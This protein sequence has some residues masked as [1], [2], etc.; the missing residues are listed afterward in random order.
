LNIPTVIES[1]DVKEYQAQSHTSLEE[2]AREVRY[3]FLTETA[4][5]TGAQAVAVGHTA[6]DHV[7]TI[8][9]HLLRGSGT[10][11]LRGLQP[12]SR[13][14]SV[15]AE[16][17]I[18]RPLLEIERNETMAYCHRYNL[19]PRQD[20]SNLSSIPMR[21][22][23]RQHLLPLLR[24]YNPQIKEALLRTAR[25]AT[26]D[27][28]F[29]DGEVA[30]AFPNIA[31]QQRDSIV[32]DK[33]GFAGLPASLKRYLLRASIEKLSGSLKDV[34]AVHI[35][36]IL[37]ALDKHAGKVVGLPGGLNFTIEYERYVL[38]PDAAA[39]SPFPVIKSPV[40]LNIPGNTVIAGWDVSA[41]IV[42]RSEATIANK[43]TNDFTACFDYE[44]TGDRLVVRGRQPG[45]RLQP[46]GMDQPK[47]LNEFMIDA[48]IPR[49]WRPR[50]PL[51]VSKRHIIWVV[52]WRIDERVKVTAS[53]KRVLR[54]RFA[55]S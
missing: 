29:I 53:S 39:I 46:L 9:M 13:W 27:M 32:I 44:R 54:L 37:N 50:I 21:N 55:R 7:E 33:A 8:L 34:E 31:K 28:V 47:K 38:G 3:N 51:V 18:I 48:R 23:I 6:D 43:E 26:D 25:I 41:D 36:D 16:L 4:E 40:K 11:G 2:A 22:R 20:S 5:K 49:S 19:Y 14:Q 15:N 10:R 42:S 12:L 35:E 24:E 30:C 45:D 52:G 1:R 17:T